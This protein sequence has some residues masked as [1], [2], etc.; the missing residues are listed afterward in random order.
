MVY[1]TRHLGKTCVIFK[2]SKSLLNAY[3]DFVILKTIEHSNFK[4]EIR[5]QNSMINKSFLREY[6][7]M[8]KIFL[9]L[10]W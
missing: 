8:C 1:L 6:K 10:R 9:G 7:E 4:K 3:G 2:L 5:G